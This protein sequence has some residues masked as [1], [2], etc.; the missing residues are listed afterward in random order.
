ML[1]GWH[2][3][4]RTGSGMILWKARE[5]MAAGEIDGDGF[6]DLAMSA[7]P[8]VGYCTPWARQAR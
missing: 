3:G 5:L 2:D 4:E 8:S 6:L 7:V 1:N